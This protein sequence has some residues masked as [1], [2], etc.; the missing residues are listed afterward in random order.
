MYATAVLLQLLY[1]NRNITRTTLGKIIIAA[2]NSTGTA[3]TLYR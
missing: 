2:R 3:L 1:T